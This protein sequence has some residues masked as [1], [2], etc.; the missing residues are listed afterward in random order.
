MSKR[1]MIILAVGLIAIIAAFLVHKY[2]TEP[3]PVP[4]PEE[5]EETET[6]EPNGPKEQTTG[7]TAD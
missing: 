5:E 4:E 7:S 2:E 6:P 1:V 3:E